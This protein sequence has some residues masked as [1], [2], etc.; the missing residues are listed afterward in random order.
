MNRIIFVSIAFALSACTHES[1]T[2]ERTSEAAQHAA[3]HPSVWAPVIGAGVFTIDHLDRRTA[4]YLSD[5][6]P[7]FGDSE[8]AGNASDDLE[9]LLHVT[10]GIS[11]FAAPVPAGEDATLHRGEHLAV[12]V[13]G[14]ALT[15]GITDGIKN[16]TRRERPNDSDDRSFP[17]GHAS[18]AFASATF[19]SANVH[20]AWG[21]SSGAQ[22][23]DAGLYTAASLTALARV[24]ADVHYPSDVLAGAALGNFMARFLDELLLADTDT[25]LV[26]AFPDRHTVIV[27][28]HHAF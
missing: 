2:W 11:A 18:Q 28:L 15:G 21:D 7:I 1:I 23:A 14:L 16:A 13:G 8:S 19:A 3:V 12:V 22:W 10:A 26:T 17:S 24:E 25:A 5:H 20:R 4:T 9:S 27:G 6:A